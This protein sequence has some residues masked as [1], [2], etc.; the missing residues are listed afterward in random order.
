[1]TADAAALTADERRWLLGRRGVG[2]WRRAVRRSLERDRRGR[3]RT[4]VRRHVRVGAR[5]VAPMTWPRPSTAAWPARAP[6]ASP[7][8]SA[9]GDGRMAVIIQ[10]MV[11]PAAAGVALTADPINGDRRTCVVT[12]VRGLG[13]RLVSGAAR[14]TNGSSRD[15]SATARR[16]PE[17]AI[18]RHQAVAIA[19]RGASH[20]GRPRDAAGHR[21]GDRRR[22]HA[23]DP[24]GPADDGAAAGGVMGIAGAGR[25]HPRCSASANGSASRSL[26]SSSRGC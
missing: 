9:A 8:T 14:A 21:V 6:P 4:L 25:L 2:P 13:D 10:R 3:R 18:D 22:R 19:T 23:L 20:R 24:P 16:Q 17:H 11:A 26:R 5:R 15:G 7:S 12:A 1:M